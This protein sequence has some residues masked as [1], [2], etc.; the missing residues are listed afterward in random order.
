MNGIISIEFIGSYNWASLLQNH[1][2]NN[3]DDI[4]AT[5]S[6]NF[7]VKCSLCLM[8][9]LVPSHILCQKSKSKLK[10]TQTNENFYF[11]DGGF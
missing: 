3:R 5:K 4:L 10:L 8:Q 11:V 6:M 2:D 9:S 1:F 7:A